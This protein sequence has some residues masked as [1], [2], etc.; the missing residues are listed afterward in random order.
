LEETSDEVERPLTLYVYYR[1]LRQCDATPQ[2]RGGI[3]LEARKMGLDRVT[4]H[5]GLGTIFYLFLVS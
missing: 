4:R 1:P 3:A 5:L 2:W